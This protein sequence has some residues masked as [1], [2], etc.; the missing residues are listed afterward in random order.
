VEVRVRVRLNY[1]FS[2]RAKTKK[3]HFQAFSRARKLVQGFSEKVKSLVSEFE[4]L[5][6]MRQYDEFS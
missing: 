2:R 3:M 1:Y 6:R 5:A 4:P